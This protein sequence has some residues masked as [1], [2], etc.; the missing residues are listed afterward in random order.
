[1]MSP[2]GIV[3]FGAGA[4]ASIVVGLPLV[5]AAGVGALAW[6]GRV[7][8][9]VPKDPPSARVPASTLSEPWRSYATQ[10][11]DAKKRFDRVVAVGRRRTAARAAA[12][13]VGAPRRGHRRVVADRPPRPRDRRRHR[14]DRHDV[15][16]GRA[17][18][19]QAH[20]RAPPADALAGPD[21][22]GVGGPAGV[23]A[24]VGD[25]RRQQPRPPPPA[26]RP[27]RRARRPHGRG[28]R[29]LRRHRHPRQRRRR[30]RQRAREPPHRDGG[31]GPGGR[32]RPHGAPVARAADIRP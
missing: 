7:L 32:R 6:G 3:L 26:R 17:R 21:E 24:P 8:A 14:P 22:A 27:L 5:A 4:A 23:G 29:R 13:A 11:E 15:G 9:A 12:A 30:P 1:M 20:G 18:R 31:D 10:A 2:L 25:A 28:Q 16:A 19:A